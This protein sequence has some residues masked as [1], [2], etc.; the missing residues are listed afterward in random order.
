MGI[1]LNIDGTEKHSERL[2][3]N[4]LSTFRIWLKLLVFVNSNIVHFLGIL[5]RFFFI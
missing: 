2:G 3:S 1:V 4:I 5:F